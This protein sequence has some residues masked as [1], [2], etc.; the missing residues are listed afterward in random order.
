MQHKGLYT[1]VFAALLMLVLVALGEGFWGSSGAAV[2]WTE[3][4][5]YGICHQIPERSFHI[6]EFPMAVNSRCFGIFGGLWIG[7]ALIPVAKDYMHEVRWVISIFLV[8]VML[9]IIDYGGNLF[10]LWENTNNTRVLLGGILG[11]SGSLVVSDLF[12]NN[13]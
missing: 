2:H 10:H 3:K 4:L 6:N 9:Q 13:N 8:A 1:G 12:Q 11:I 5:F 7:W